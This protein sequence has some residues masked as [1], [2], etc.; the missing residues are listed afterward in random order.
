TNAI[1]NVTSPG[2]KTVYFLTGH[3][4][5]NPSDSG[6]P[7]GYGS[8]KEYL[9]KDNYLVK[10]LNLITEKK[11]P[12]DCAVLI[13]ADPQKPLLDDEM[14]AIETYLKGEGKALFLSDALA[15]GNLPDLT[16]KYG[17]V[18][19]SNIVLDVRH[20]VQN[21]PFFFVPDFRFHKITEQLKTENLGLILLTARSVEI[22]KPERSEYTYQELVASSAGPDSWAESNLKQKPLKFD[23]GKDIQGPVP[24]AIAVSLKGQPGKEGEGKS[25]LVVIGSA[26][27]ASNMAA[28]L[29][30]NLD[31]T[32]NSVNWLA[33]EK[34]KIS[35]R[36]KGKE[37][38]RLLIPTASMSFIFLI[39][40]V[41]VPGVCVAF[42]G[43]V[44][45]KRRSL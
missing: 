44:W 40:V 16:K 33:E 1:L 7:K 10:I 13:V 14:K 27:F 11:V 41:L 25:K 28:R 39:T 4:E 24:I 45:W 5:R 32:V 42:G 6:G 12:P 22:A 17:I 9:E 8:L 19:G 29:V 31:F 43:W 21:N 38:D 34:E 2:Q 26:G 15:K 37:F 23:R 30:A 3:G 35:I 36:P 18:M 20:S